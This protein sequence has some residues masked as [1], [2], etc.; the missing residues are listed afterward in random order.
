MGRTEM[1]AAVPITLGREFSAFAEAVAR[2]RWRSFKCEERLRLVNLGGTAIGT[3]LTA[4]KRY[5]FR[6]IE[7]LRALTG[8][9]LARNENA[10]DATANADAFVE[11]SGILK[12]CAANFSKIAGDLRLLH[13][14]KEIAL[15]PLQAGSSIMP[16][17][18]NPVTMEGI[19]TSGF[20]GA[21]EPISSSAMRRPRNLA[22]QRISAA[23][24]QRLARIRGNVTWRGKVAVPPD[25]RR[26]RRCE[27][28][29]GASFTIVRH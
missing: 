11:V 14:L 18:I 28:V 1:Q 2:D 21:G 15:P 5:I 10:I 26:D 22:D 29:R 25:R 23:D 24:R 13:F 20:G 19:F 12:A 16:A 27:D 7:V 8:M 6:V 3:G 9:G 17:K 4:P